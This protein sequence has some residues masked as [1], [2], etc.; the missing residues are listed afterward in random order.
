MQELT[1]KDILKILKKRWLQIAAFCI[2][3]TLAAGMYYQ[4]QPDVY[5]AQ[6]KL[7]VLLVYTD[8]S[9]QTRVDPYISQ[10]FIGDFAQLI[11]IP[12]IMD[13]S[14]EQMNV[15]DAE[16]SSVSIG[17][18]E[19]PNTG[20]LLLSASG[21]D[22]DL[23]MKKANVVSQVFVEYIADEIMENLVRVIEKAS[24]PIILVGPAR[25]KNTLM[26]GVV[27][28]LL[29]IG[30]ALAIEML[31]TT[32]RTSD[33]VENALGV[34]VLASIQN[35][36]KDLDRFLQKR[37]P[38]EMLSKGIP[39]LTRENVKALVTNIQ[40]AA[41]AHPAQ[42]VLITS[43][44]AGE[45]KSSLLLLLSEAFADLGKRVLVVDL[46]MRNPSIGQYLGTRGRN[47]LFDYMVGHTR[48]EEVICK[49]SNPGLHFIDSRHRLASVSQVVNFEVF[50]KFL[51]TVKRVY[52]VILFDTPPLGLFIDAAALANKMD[53]TLLV[54]GSG[55][56]DRAVVKDVVEQLH[57][58]NANVLGAALNYVDYPKS[59][60]HFYGKKY[61]YGA[62]K[63]DQTTS[64]RK[65]A[66]EA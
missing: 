19:V 26:A 63:K 47:D 14:K 65:A 22:K 36:K 41:I 35:Y 50:E 4:Q 2:F 54:I 64:F 39:I 28:L 27:G 48:L 12:A 53:A 59:Q 40:F 51:D 16:F 61:G 30:V 15:A 38:G 62:E 8:N 1:V 37:L 32:L 44:I 60:Q 20:I 29:A 52:D 33:A 34:P 6:A 11:Q 66:Q 9:N 43:S 10:R 58:A 13:K 24:L 21:V 49:T 55:M 42:T 57:K 7:Q 5:R 45:G 23:C 46:D 17:I 31:N 25:M 56:S 3:V 18:S